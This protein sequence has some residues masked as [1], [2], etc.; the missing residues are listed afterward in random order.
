MSQSQSALLGCLSKDRPEQHH[1]AAT[2]NAPKEAL[3]SQSS[4]PIPR[5]KT[6]SRPERDCGRRDDVDPSRLIRPEALIG[7]TQSVRAWDISIGA[8]IWGQFNP[9]L[10]AG[11]DSSMPRRVVGEVDKQTRQ[12]LLMM[13]LNRADPE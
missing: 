12:N 2:T 1:H 3:D 7:S 6:M 10:G 5:L 8:H 9:S 4:L 11:T 13:A